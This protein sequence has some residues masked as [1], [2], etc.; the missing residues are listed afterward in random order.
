LDKLIVS[1]WKFRELAK[2]ATVIL[3]ILERKH[4]LLGIESTHKHVTVDA[5]EAVVSFANLDLSKLS[6]EELGWLEIIIAKS[7]P[8]ADGAI[9]GQYEAL[10]NA[11]GSADGTGI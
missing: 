1:H 5:P 3:N 4:K 9:E 8:L 2:H 10:L 7:M 11:Q 6:T